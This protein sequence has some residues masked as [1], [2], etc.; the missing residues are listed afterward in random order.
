MKEKDMSLR[1][2]ERVALAFLVAITSPVFAYS[3]ETEKARVSNDRS[4]VIASLLFFGASLLTSG[5]MTVKN[6]QFGPEEG[7]R[8][9]CIK[10]EK[11]IIWGRAQ[12]FFGAILVLLGLIAI[13]H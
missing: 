6:K 13:L 10:G 8:G 9:N 3:L 1:L 7:L 5:G 12:L 4:A 11:A 2:S